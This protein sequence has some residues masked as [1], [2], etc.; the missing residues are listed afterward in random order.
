M[1][2]EITGSKRIT[3]EQVA[4]A[5]CDNFW[6]NLRNHRGDEDLRAWKADRLTYVQNYIAAFYL[7][8]P[9]KLR[10]LP[11]VAHDIAMTV[12][13]WFVERGYAEQDVNGVWHVCD[14]V[15]ED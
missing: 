9:S 4:D 15:R 10:K 2:R 13:R 11:Q 5:I 8:E 3:K 7:V 12:E 6:V 14:D 1:F